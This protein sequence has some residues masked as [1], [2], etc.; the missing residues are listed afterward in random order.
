MKTNH[1]EHNLAT[2]IAHTTSES[3]N[4]KA[5]ETCYAQ[6]DPEG[7]GANTTQNNQLT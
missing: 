4:T 2:L 1:I 6:Q 7:P 5:Y 3:V